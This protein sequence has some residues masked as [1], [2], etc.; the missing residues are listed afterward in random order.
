MGS[1]NTMTAPPTP[2]T[3]AYEL[4]CRHLSLIQRLSLEE[5]QYFYEDGYSFTMMWV[6]KINS[7]HCVQVRPFHYQDSVPPYDRL[8]ARLLLFRANREAFFELSNNGLRALDSDRVHEIP[9]GRLEFERVNDI[10]DKETQ[11]SMIKV[12]QLIETL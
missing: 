5:N 3:R 1:L 8:L 11:E 2:N 4:L 10:W 6:Y 12:S 7:S 9:Q